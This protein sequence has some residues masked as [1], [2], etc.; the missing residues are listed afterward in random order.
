M[1][2]DFFFF[3]LTSSTSR[4]IRQK[5]IEI[6]KIC[7]RRRGG[8]GNICGIKRWGVGKHISTSNLLSACTHPQF[9][10]SS[11]SLV[12][13]VSPNSDSLSSDPITGYNMRSNGS[14]PYTYLLPRTTEQVQLC[15]YDGLLG[16][17]LLNSIIVSDPFLH[18]AHVTM[19]SVPIRQST[20]KH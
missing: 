3:F 16:C 2:I 4:L 7:L 14:G 5:R 15:L 18:V 19:D 12:L 8:E 20:S 9:E 11:I 17:T 1:K 6:R 13:V 10:L